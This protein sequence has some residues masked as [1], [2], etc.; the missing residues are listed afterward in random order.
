VR[1]KF[2]ELGRNFSDCIN[3]WLWP[4]VLAEAPLHRKLL[5]IGTL[6]CAHFEA[7]RPVG[8]RPM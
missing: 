3:E 1:Y 7:R 8:L 2:P 6:L 5:R 4:R